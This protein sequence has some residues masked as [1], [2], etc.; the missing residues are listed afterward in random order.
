[1][2]DKTFI[3]NLPIAGVCLPLEKEG[4]WDP[5]Y[6]ST[7]RRAPRDLETETRDEANW[8]P[9]E[10]PWSSPPEKNHVC[11]LPP[12]HSVKAGLGKAVQIHI[13]LLILSG[14]EVDF[15]ISGAVAE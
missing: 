2:K 13:F 11:F 1:M 14:L 3:Y 15:E 8:D 4:H 7:L 9:M 5:S 10:P 6:Q 12:H